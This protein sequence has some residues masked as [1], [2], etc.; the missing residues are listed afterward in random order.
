VF[1]HKILFFSFVVNFVS[2]VILLIGLLLSP[3]NADIN[4]RGAQGIHFLHPIAGIQEPFCSVTH[5]DEPEYP[6][7]TEELFQLDLL[8][9][10][11]E[12]K[13]S[14]MGDGPTL[15]FEGSKS[16]FLTFTAS[17]PLS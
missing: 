1:W 9:E 3:A 7:I 4:A 8:C 12:Y 5:E 2:L 11:K 14:S 15:D 6:L 13:C 10:G 16:I 17:Y